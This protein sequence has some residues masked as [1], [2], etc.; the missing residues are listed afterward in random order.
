MESLKELGPFVRLCQ[1]SG[2][3]PFRL[4]IDPELKHFQRFQLSL[5]HPLTFWYISI[6]LLLQLSSILD[7]HYEP[8]L[9]EISTLDTCIERVTK[10][11]ERIALV[12][13][14]LRCS[15]LRKYVELIQ[16]VNEPLR[17]FLRTNSFNKALR[18]RAY[19]GTAWV[20]TMVNK[21]SLISIII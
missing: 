19:I 3:F 12:S 1:I 14:V 13:I 6:Q 15:H 20:L 11:G 17:Y 2:L 9:L 16:R 8:L 5:L 4:K 10:I 21:L 18:R 7:L